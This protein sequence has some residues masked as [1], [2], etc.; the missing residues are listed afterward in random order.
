[1][2]GQFSGLVYAVN[3]QQKYLTLRDVVD[4]NTGAKYPK[5]VR[6]F[7]MS[8]ITSCE[9]LSKE[10]ESGETVTQKIKVLSDLLMETN[11]VESHAHIRPS[12]YIDSLATGTVLRQSITES[13][14]E[15]EK[16]PAETCSPPETPA[17][18]NKPGDQVK[19]HSVI[20]LT[21][22]DDCFKE[23]VHD[24]ERVG[25]NR[26]GCL[27]LLQIA[28][29]DFIYIYDIL[30][31]GDL[32]FVHGLRD[33]L[34]SDRIHKAVFNC[35]FLSDILWNQYGVVLNYVFDCQVA[36]VFLD[37]MHSLGKYKRFLPCLASSLMY[38]LA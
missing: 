10:E 34:E 23:S 33:V 27:S 31:R 17:V 25:S 11:I 16:E 37:R 15:E 5:P 30:Q 9:V 1:V 13:A 26:S 3:Q 8:Q 36:I 28:T 19:Q 21:E 29:N 20:V 35:R 38:Y 6:N 12:I 18:L 22:V 32:V 4:L 24:I 7:L 2:D 14:Q